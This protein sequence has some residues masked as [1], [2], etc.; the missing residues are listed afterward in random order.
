[1]DSKAEDDKSEEHRRTD[2]T[3]LGTTPNQASSSSHGQH[4]DYVQ[5]PPQIG[6]LGQGS[7]PSHDQSP[8]RPPINS[9]G[10]EEHGSPPVPIQNGPSFER[11]EAGFPTSPIQNSPS[12]GREEGGFPTLPIQN[13]SLN[14]SGE[15]VVPPLMAS[16]LRP[17][18]PRALTAP[19]NPTYVHYWDHLGRERYSGPSRDVWPHAVDRHGFVVRQTGGIVSPTENGGTQDA[20]G[21]VNDYTLSTRAAAERPNDY[22]PSTPGANLSPWQSRSILR[23]QNEAP[24]QNQPQRPQ[25]PPTNIASE[26]DMTP[27]KTKRRSQQNSVRRVE[28][29][30]RKSD[31]SSP[32]K[33]SKTWK[34]PHRSRQATEPNTPRRLT[35]D[36]ALAANTPSTPSS[37]ASGTKLK[38]VNQRAIRDAEAARAAEAARITPWTLPNSSHRRTAQIPVAASSS[39]SA[40]LGSETAPNSSNGRTGRDTGSASSCTSTRTAP[41][42]LPSPNSSHRRPDC[43]IVAAS[44]SA[45]TSCASGSRH[46]RLTQN[47]QWL[48]MPIEIPRQADLKAARLNR[49][50][51]A[52]A[53]SQSDERPRSS[54][55]NRRASTAPDDNRDPDETESES[56][57]VKAYN[58]SRSRSKNRTPPDKRNPDDEFGDGEGRPFEGKGK[59]KA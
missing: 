20:P 12:F 17:S 45:S 53:S 29:R 37:S 55:V 4:A 26:G 25:T 43:D 31:H 50:R 18:R 44:S 40:D 5:H 47:G 3:D 16:A 22:D 15:D 10:R 59:G 23:S 7:P 9:F 32:Q 2:I 46:Y 24:N 13:A 52:V 27:R 14:G 35:G 19:S 1:M 28:H 39:T 54:Q 21:R 8:S 57:S 11:V 34:L 51:L 33:I 48:R 41:W 58:E 38:L 30:R 6:T 36:N 42:T 56:E 49:R